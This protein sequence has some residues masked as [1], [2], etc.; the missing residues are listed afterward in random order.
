LSIHKA[1]SGRW[2]I[3][4]REGSRNRSRTVDRKSDALRL[5]AE[6]RRQRQL[7]GLIPNR[8]G[9]VTL[10]D[11]ASQWLNG[12][13]DLARRTDELY[14]FLLAHHIMDDLG[15]FPLNELRTSTL[16]D[17]QQ[18]RLRQGAG[19][20]TLAKAVTLLKQILEEA[21][22]HEHMQRNPATSLQVHKPEKRIP[23]PATPEQ[24]EAMR[25][26]FLAKDHLGDATL[27][28]VLGYGGLRPGEALALRFS[29]IDHGTISVTKAIAYGEEKGTKTGATRV[30][31][32]PSAVARDLAEWKLGSP[33]P[34]GLVFPRKTDGKPWTRHDWNNWRRRRFGPASK[35]AGLEGFRP[36]D[37]RHS[38]ASLLIAENR[39]ITEVAAQL[40]HSPA[41]CLSVY[42]HVMEQAR[43]R[44]SVSA[45]AWIAEA[46]SAARGEATG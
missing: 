28:S 20:V 3:R 2:E 22:A 10:E 8:V 14:T 41:V 33:M 12:R 7:G 26:W 35:A 19:P 36:Y 18:R 15:H 45:G 13:T 30:V 46:R 16:R 37:M 40:G 17:W 24:I 9:G 32:P 6:I 43:D 31:R 38:A 21:V 39:P 23:I 34:F 44:E 27:L 29:D 25:G 1:A 42:A 11:F 5:D 4:W